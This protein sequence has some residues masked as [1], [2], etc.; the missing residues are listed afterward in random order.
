MGV[1][2]T[3]KAIN[4]ELAKRGHN[5]V[6]EKGCDYFYLLGGDAAD[7]LDKTVQV[8]KVSSLT[9]DEWM[10]EFDK[11]KQHNAQIFQ[12]AKGK[13]TRKAGK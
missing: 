12:A 4:S 13:P 6:L 2:L 1:P 9:L 5:L 8:P 7:W 3:L 11:L 10:A